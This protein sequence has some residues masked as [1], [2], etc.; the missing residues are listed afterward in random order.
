MGSEATWQV[1]APTAAPSAGVAVSPALASSLDRFLGLGVLRPFRRGETGSIIT[2]RGYALL[3]A[4]V[5]QVLGTEAMGPQTFGELPWRPEFGSYLYRLR[6]RRLDATTRELA[7]T[8]V[9]DA[10]MRWLPEIELTDFGIQE[11]K[12]S[13]D[14]A[15]DT[16]EITVRWRLRRIGPA[17]P[18]A[19]TPGE[20][21]TT[22]TF[23]V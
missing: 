1:E 13:A 18:E 15:R 17:L 5:G 21:M 4:Y 19:V 9:I 2:G 8:Y 6:H 23:E 14:S 20:A 3:Q 22:V 7:R 10:L 11:K 16:L 12:S